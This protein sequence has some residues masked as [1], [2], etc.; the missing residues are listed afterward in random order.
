VI[1]L[2]TTVLAYAVGSE[3]PL[4]KP[5]R[6]LLAAQRDGLIDA[7][8]TVEVLQEFL[9]IRARRHGRDDA[10]HLTKELVDAF[11]LLQTSREDLIAGADLYARHLDLGAFDAVLAAVAIDREVSAFVSAD[12]SFRGITDLRWVDLAARDLRSRLASS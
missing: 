3:H 5:A 11:D 8:T 6:W 2:D 7:T 1:L 9:H 10:V 12:R 4:R